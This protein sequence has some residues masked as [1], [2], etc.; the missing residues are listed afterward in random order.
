MRIR[1]TN[2]TKKEEKKKKRKDKF[3]TF[4]KHEPRWKR[5]VEAKFKE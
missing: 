1:D 4:F 3:L 2:I 5:D